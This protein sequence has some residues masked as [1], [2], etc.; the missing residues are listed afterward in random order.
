MRRCVTP[1]SRIVR[2]NNSNSRSD[3]VILKIKKQA[4]DVLSAFAM[5]NRKFHEYRGSGDGSVATEE[6]IDKVGKE[7]FGEDF[8]MADR[9]KPSETL[10]E[11]AE[12]DQGM[13]GLGDLVA[14]TIKVTTGI[15]AKEDCGCKKRQAALNK[16]V[17]FHSKKKKK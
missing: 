3:E 4:M 11:M 1:V 14:K 15:E 5:A 8:S 7:H 9:L 10:N 17:P 6:E 12:E 16:W 13:R 2:D